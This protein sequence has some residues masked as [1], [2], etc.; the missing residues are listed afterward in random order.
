VPVPTAAD[1]R[2]CAGTSA[3]A[4]AVPPFDP[5]RLPASLAAR[6]NDLRPA[7]LGLAPAIGT[8]LA[9]LRAA[10]GALYASMTGSGATC[11]ALF[12]DPGEAVETARRIARDRPG[13]WTYAGRLL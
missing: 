12:G 3:S 5:E 10:A 1:F 7:A 2:A 4:A 8:V 6:G 11:F 13:W 9:E